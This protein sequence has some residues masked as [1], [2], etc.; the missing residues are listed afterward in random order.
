MLYVDLDYF[1]DKQNVPYIKFL[2]KLSIQNLQK[3][4]L[5]INTSTWHEMNQQNFKENNISALMKVKITCKIHVVHQ[6]FFSKF[7]N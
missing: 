5:I 2:L 1:I 6:N 4:M 3:Y 7:W